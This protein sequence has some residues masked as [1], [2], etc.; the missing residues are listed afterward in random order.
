M[1]KAQWTNLNSGIN[2]NLN[3]LYFVNTNTGIVAGSNGIYYTSTGGAG[4]SAW[5]RI[6]PSS[7]ADLALYNRC[8]FRKI[9]AD[10]NTGK[11]Y[12]CGWDTINT[13]AVI[14]CLKLSDLSSSFVFTGAA[15]TKLFDI[16][17]NT[18]S[19]I[20]V[21]T[22]G[23]V[24]RYQ[25]SNN[26]ILVYP[27][28]T[29]KTLRSLTFD[30]SSSGVIIAAGDSIL[31]RASPGNLSLD[32]SVLVPLNFIVSSVQCDVQSLFAT[33][34]SGYYTAPL[35][36]FAALAPNSSYKG[37]PLNPIWISRSGSGFRYFVTTGHGLYKI[38]NGLVLEP[39]PASAQYVLNAMHF[40]GSSTTAFACGNN[41]LILQGLNE[42]GPTVPYLNVSLSTGCRS[43]IIT[44]YRQAGGSSNA[45]SVNVYDASNNQVNS[46][47]TSCALSYG[48]QWPVSGTFSFH[49][50][51]TN[52]L[53]SDTVSFTR[54]I[55][56]PPP[57]N[58]P[59]SFNDSLL[60]K[61]EQIM[62][63]VGNT[64]AGWDYNLRR[65]GD[66]NNY[67]T[68][69]G[70]GSTLNFQSSLLQTAGNYTI[71]VSA[72]TNGCRKSFTNTIPIVIEKPKGR[73][74]AQYVNASVNEPV[75]ITATTNDAQNFKWTF[76]NSA[77]SPL[78]MGSTVQNAFNSIGIKSVE[79]ISWSN[80]GC[81][82]TS[83]LKVTR[84]VDDAMLAGNCYTINIAG[85]DPSYN[86]AYPQLASQEDLKVVS[87]GILIGGS[88]YKYVMKSVIGD[89]LA[90]TEA[91]G[92]YLA[93]YN[94]KGVLRWNW[95]THH[96]GYDCPTCYYTPKPAVYGI[97]PLADGS[98]VFAGAEDPGVWM[99]FS[100]GDS[101]QI[102]SG[103]P[104]PINAYKGFI[105]KASA[106]GALQWRGVLTGGFVKKLRQDKAGNFWVLCDRANQLYYTRAGGPTVTI[107]NTSTSFDGQAMLIKFDANGNYLASSRI[108]HSGQNT[109]RIRDFIV[110]NSG[111]PWVSGMLEQSVTFYN[112]NG[113][114]A[115]TAM[116]VTPSSSMNIYIVKY[117]SNG[118]YQFHIRGGVVTNN[119]TSFRRA[120]PAAMAVDST[121]HVY[122]LGMSIGFGA[123]DSLT[124]IHSNGT[125]FT[126]NVAG[127]FLSRFDANGTV[128]WTTGT[129]N[130]NYY[131]DGHTI[132]ATSSAVY[133]T[134]TVL[135]NGQGVWSGEVT[136]TDGNRYGMSLN[137]TSFLLAK[138]SYAGAL[139]Q[140]GQSQSTGSGHIT[141][142]TVVKD[143]GR[144]Y[145]GLRAY[146]VPVTPQQYT[147]FGQSV[148]TEG[149]D[150][151]FTVLNDSMCYSPA[152][153]TAN[154]GADQTVCSGA[155]AT[156]GT[157]SMP[158]TYYSWTSSTAGFSSTASSPVV[159]P[160]VTTTY[161]L[162]QIN[163]AGFRSFDTVLVS[164]NGPIADAGNNKV[165]CAGEPVTI[166]TTA[167]NGTLSWSSNPSGFT[168]SAS[169]VV[170]SPA[171]TTTYFLQATNGGSC[172]GRDTITVTVN[173]L[174]PANAGPDVSGC[175]GGPK[176]IGTSGF[177]IFNYS[178]SPT[179][180]LS[181]SN[182]DITFANP[183][184]TTTYI[185]TVT[186]AATGCIKKDTVV[187]NVGTPP[188]P[189]IATSG[190]TTFCT[191][192]SVL[193]TSSSATG[194]RWELNG[195]QITGANGSTYTASV[196]GSYTVSITGQCS[197][198]P[199]SAIVVTV[200][201]FPSQ[202]IIVGDSS[203]CAGSNTIIASSASSGN[204][205][206]LNNVAITGATNQLLNVSNPGAYQVRSTVNGCS[207]PASLVMNVTSKPLPPTPVITQTGNTLN[208]SAPSNNQ[209]YLNNTII[210]A[211]NG[212][213][214]I[215]QTDGV[216]TVR[217]TT[218]GCSS[219]S[220][221]FNY[222]TTAVTDPFALTG[223]TITPNP[224]TDLIELRYASGATP[225][226]L[227]IIDALGRGVYKSSFVNVTQVT[228]SAFASGIYVVEIIDER[229][230]KSLQKIVIKK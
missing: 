57:I 112:G 29:N 7:S 218:N 140:L 21:G 91:G 31:L 62:V 63:T 142:M 162:S 223:F 49:Y 180:A 115:A 163:S 8:H 214:L 141:P 120:S 152:A 69:A 222:V 147:L 67:G 105:A 73:L 79:L 126:T 18:S 77:S 158:N 220:Q 212:S 66:N 99:Y 169:T 188:A 111:N 209:W 16:R 225:V 3:D 83:Q 171:V 13:N 34:P 60:C 41:G 45:C 14:F 22:N 98:I 82:D 144:F 27:P 117:N 148:Q 216:Y 106:T 86:V 203:Y 157:S 134:S 127:F 64:Q 101:V 132:T 9:A 197:S 39:Q 26:T 181:S 156:I 159:S 37:G 85:V 205:W 113:N 139:E 192:G 40:A 96:P 207:S 78:L 189:T 129:T 123:N 150:G 70:N 76:D 71:E 48:T 68:G 42:G 12:I 217:V 186:N 131:S 138:Y 137:Y 36:N 121:N 108:D 35:S 58:L 103:G 44:F 30:E 100:N 213:S 116:A 59:L 136:S 119:G 24:V 165:I 87:D 84:V 93:K 89:T 172:T 50:I 179:T 10:L 23:L 61:A 228:T 81:Y 92:L 145:L 154:A 183:A 52:G 185:L 230:G 80:N 206:Y 210:S 107:L 1:A 215:P 164:V 25:L 160:Q 47:S 174:P 184:T 19:L 161:Y 167:S 102:T 155:S 110:D 28:L 33:G 75:Y 55:P 17:A 54:L 32:N 65:Q 151:L 6:I 15:N 178:W 175:S 74:S 190:P 201:P 51:A 43:D 104:A 193:L 221:P 46:F 95:Y 133:I 56:E 20:A 11:Y 143:N 226:K 166:G 94:K 109:S 202:P 200:H 118:D 125:S 208:S 122:V 2:D 130:G 146:N 211:A 224:F 97:E 199:S 88:A 124:F 198:A 173:P 219:I 128:L 149:S 229:K 38:Q 168:S 53:L 90:R 204:Q 114:I 153:T 135:L 191:G 227:R 176:M 182:T 196:S 5:T 170:V 72:Q 194:N 195:T 4:A 187:V 177:S